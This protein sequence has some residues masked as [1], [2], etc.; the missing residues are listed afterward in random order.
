MLKEPYLIQFIEMLSNLNCSLNNLKEN[1]PS[2][3]I[4]KCLIP[5]KS[6]IT[7]A[8]YNEKENVIYMQP[9]TPE[10]IMYH[11][12]FHVAST[13][14]E[15]NKVISGFSIVLPDNTL[16]LGLNEGYTQLLTE[17]YFGSVSNYFQ[18]YPYEVI[19]AAQFE[20]IIGS[21]MF[22]LYL[23]ANLLDLKHKFLQYGSE[24]DFNTFFTCLDY[25]NKNLYKINSDVEILKNC[26][27]KVSDILIKCFNR[28]ENNEE[29]LKE[30][31]EDMDLCMEINNELYDFCPSHF[32]KRYK[33][34]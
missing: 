21:Q 30:Y 22:D 33:E 29:S 20:K 13:K 11:E 15:Y 1:L 32:P 16:N 28:K 4:K 18:V 8:S 27:K 9:K 6:I 31:I 3:K 26:M 34:R 7:A 2:L 10:I 5:Q 19:I 12:L 24:A 17:R 23:T 25:I 14:R